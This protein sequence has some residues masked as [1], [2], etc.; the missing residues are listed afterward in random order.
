MKRK[1]VKQGAATMM[2]SLPA[3]WIK[4]HGL[5][6][7][8]EIEVEETGDGSL[9]IE[10]KNK[11]GKKETAINITSMTES[12]IRTLLTNA[13][14]LGYDRIDVK[15]AYDNAL[16]IIE[17]TLKKQLLGFQIVKKENKKCIIENI[18]EPSAEQFENIYS[19]MI[20]NIKELFDIAKDALEG[21]NK[22]IY[23]S[24][25]IEDSIKQFDNFCR[26]IIAKENLYGHCALQWAFHAELIHAQREI[27]LLLRH[28]KNNKTKCNKE[29]LSLLEECRE[30]FEMI[31]R[32]HKEKNIELLERAHDMEKKLVYEAGH[33][34]LEKG[35]DSI[36]VKHIVNAI[37]EF[38]LCASHLMGMA[39]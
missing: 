36:I 8:D 27:Y 26:R 1:L 15:Y 38:Y 25:D 32:A 37:R 12:S 19:K 34:L 13:Y 20:L 30:M 21:S 35:K 18:T 39:I 5:D 9:V 24:E 28:L 22:R 29:I 2:V 10:M 14:R 11:K 31:V 3:K 7:G 17:H 4:Q 23:E 33:K 6:K 16:R